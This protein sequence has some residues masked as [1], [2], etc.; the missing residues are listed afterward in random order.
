MLVDG[1]DLGSVHLESV[2]KSLSVLA[3]N[4][5]RVFEK[6]RNDVLVRFAVKKILEPVGVVSGRGLISLLIGG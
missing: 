2:L 5:H 3:E 4:R 1:L 6:H